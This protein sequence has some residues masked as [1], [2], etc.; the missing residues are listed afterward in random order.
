[1]AN[2]KVIRDATESIRQT[3]TWLF[4]LYFG[5]KAGKTLMEKT[6]DDTVLFLVKVQIKTSA[7][8]FTPTTKFQLFL[9]C[10]INKAKI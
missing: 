1:M 6:W 8:D 2:A 7:F 3:K 5:Q 9:K 10:L 4:R